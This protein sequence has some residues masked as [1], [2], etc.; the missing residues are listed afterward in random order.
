[1]L[2]EFFSNLRFRL[3][4]LIFLAILPVSG[5]IFY[6]AAEQRRLAI[7]DVESDALLLTGLTAANQQQVIEGAASAAGGMHDFIV[8]KA[9]FQNTDGS[10]GGLVG[11]M[12]DITARKQVEEALRL[13]EEQYRTIFETTGTATVLVEE[14]TTISLMNS[15]FQ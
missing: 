12:I 3:L 15:R 13:S 2:M 1:M 6:S 8:R 10:L 5:L 14:D 9:P 11:V 4:L 7:A